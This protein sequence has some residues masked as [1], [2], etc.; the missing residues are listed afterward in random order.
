MSGNRDKLL[1][2]GPGA[3]LQWRVRNRNGTDH[4]PIARY[5]DLSGIYDFVIPSSKINDED[6][7]AGYDTAPTI[8]SGPSEKNLMTLA[9]ERIAPALDGVAC[10]VA[11]SRGGN[12]TIPALWGLPKF[13][14]NPVPCFVVNGMC[15][16][17]LGVRR[18]GLPAGLRLFVA[19]GGEDRLTNRP[20]G[21]NPVTGASDEKG[22]AKA[23]MDVLRT[24]KDGNIFLY[25]NPTDEHMIYSLD[26]D[27]LMLRLI[28]GFLNGGGFGAIPTGGLL[29]V[30]DMAAITGFKVISSGGYRSRETRRSNNIRRGV[31]CRKR[32]MG[33]RSSRSR[34][35]SRRGRIS[36]DV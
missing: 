35:R 26:K 30:R 4:G 20:D 28:N 13:Q 3:A 34:R 27:K 18:N 8:L 22:V 14:Q 12:H 31:L 25:W 1:I 15:C 11:G 2:I 23:I 33:T 21:I 5:I 10:V 19:I 6:F 9:K 16:L 32:K 7:F 29:L 24:G 17:N 36:R